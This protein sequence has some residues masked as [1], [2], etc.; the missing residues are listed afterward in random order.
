MIYANSKSIFQSIIAAKK[1]GVM[2]KVILVDSR[3]FLDGRE[4]YT[5]YTNAGVDCSYILLQSMSFHI[6]EA[7][8]VVLNLDS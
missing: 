2:F 6:K 5:H 3:P 8:K 7:S 1:E 4:A